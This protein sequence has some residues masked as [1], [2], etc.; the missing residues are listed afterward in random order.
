MEEVKFYRCRHCGN[1]IVHLVSSGVNV[2]CCGEP[3]QLLVPNTQ[4]ASQEKHVPVIEKSGNILTVRVGSVEHQSLPEH[5][6]EWIAVQ[7]PAGLQINYLKP[8]DKPEA[9]FALAD[10][11]TEVTVY[12]FCNL[13]GLW[14]ST[15]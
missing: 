6:I 11:A 3:M 14:K 13:H 8:G 4:D 1:V 12:E 7:T 2:V 15:L 5:F 10:D 9:R